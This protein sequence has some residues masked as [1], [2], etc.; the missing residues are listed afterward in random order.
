MRGDDRDGIEDLPDRREVGQ[1]VPRHVL[2]EKPAHDDGGVGR[3]QRVAVG[4]GTGRHGVADGAA[5]SGLDVE[6]DRLAKRF[7]N[8][9]VHQAHQRL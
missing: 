5:C 4:R 6:N 8:L 2:D 9:L 3:E 1:R 7:G